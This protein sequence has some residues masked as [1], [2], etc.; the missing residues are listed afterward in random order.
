[1]TAHYKIVLI[2]E[3]IFFENTDTTEPIIGFISCKYLQAESLD[4]AIATAKR[5][6]LMHWNHSFNADRKL[7]MPKLSLA[8]G[9]PIKRL[10][11][12]KAGNDYHWFSNDETKQ[13]LLDDCI[14][15]KRKWYQL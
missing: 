3:N 5:D 1:M 15:S 4:L 7:G 13:T 14:N 8:H 12:P 10:I 2:G 11:M 6:L 9:A